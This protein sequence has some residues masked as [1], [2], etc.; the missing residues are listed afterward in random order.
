[1][2]RAQPRLPRPGDI[3]GPIIDEQHLVGGPPEPPQR[4]GE[5]GWIGLG[6]AEVRA[7]DER[8]EQG[9]LGLGGDR[10]RE[11]ARRVGEHRELASTPPGCAQDLERVGIEVGPAAD[12]DPR[13]LGEQ[14]VVIE[15]GLGHRR[16]ER[17]RR[18]APVIWRPV[19]PVPVVKHI[20]GESEQV[21]HR[22]DRLG[23]LGDGDHLGVVD[24]ERARYIAVVRRGHGS[25]LDRRAAVTRWRKCECVV[26]GM[27]P[28]WVAIATL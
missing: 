17:A 5:G 15:L 8:P 6:Q 4:G 23:R 19:P 27:G 16:P 11:I 20:G 26:H 10:G 24:E 12:V 9:H 13:E 7:E 14:V 18:A 1:M 3:D 22:L 21:G 25:H 28:Q 2:D